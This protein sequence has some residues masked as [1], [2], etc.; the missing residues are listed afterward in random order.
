MHDITLSSYGSQSTEPSP[1]NRMM[2][3]F[4]ADFRDG[5]DINL[6]VGY[7]NDRTIP[8]RAILHAMEAIIDDP[9][10]YRIAFNYGGSA[11]SANLIDSLRRFIVRNK[12]GGISDDLL[13]G[14]KII[15]GVSGATSL[16]EGVAQVIKP[17]IVVTTDPMY[18]IYCEFLERAG[19][20]VLTVPEDAHGI[21]TDLIEDKIAGCL[22]EISFFY[23]V[24]IGNPTSSILSNDRRRELVDIV[25][26]ASM[27][28]GRTIPLFLDTAYEH[29]IHDTSI[30]PPV[31]GLT[32]DTADLVYELGTMSKI[33]APGL[34]IGYMIGPDTEL[35]HAMVQRINDVGFS[36]SLINQEIAGY[37]LDHHVQE[38][39]DTVNTQYRLKAAAAKQCIDEHLGE[40]V[41]ESIGGSAGFYYYL[42]LKDILTEEGSD[43]FNYCSRI[44]GIPEIDG[45]TT[46][47]KP[48]VLYVPGAFCVHPRGDMTGKGRRQ[49]RISYGYEEIDKIKEGIAIMGEALQYV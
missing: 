36:A 33:L 12:I 24:T 19:F 47:R 8:Q 44:T 38:Q 2:A 30:E 27:K 11:G 15:I 43:F 25:T 28:E 23:I 20:T 48:R 42:T 37:L 4:A 1:V 31:S 49:L 34:R 3:A 29:L 16:L 17:G 41:E 45:P 32:I 26:K 40:Y 6:G 21:R 39:I 5:R 9:Q 10:H 46:D 35:M 14:K 18:Y 13:S 7:V 22:S